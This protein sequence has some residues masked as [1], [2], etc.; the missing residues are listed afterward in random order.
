MNKR[1]GLVA[2]FALI[3]AIAHGADNNIMLG[4][5]ELYL[6]ASA[7]A[8]S[9]PPVLYPFQFQASSPTS[10]AITLPAS[11]GVQLPADSNGGYG[12]STFYTT[13]AAMDAAYPDGTY[14][15]TP[16]GSAPYTLQLINDLYPAAPPTLV[17]GGTWQNGVLV[18]DPTQNATL[19]INT[20]PGYGSGNGSHEE[21]QVNSESGDNVNL[22]QSI[23]SIAVA[24]MPATTTPFTTLAIPSGTLKAGYVYQATINFDAVGT[25]ISS[26]TLAVS[27]FSDSTYFYIVG[28]STPAVAPPVITSQP[29][30]QV[31]PLGSSVTFNIGVTYNGSTSS[32]SNA[33]TSY[34][35]Y[36]NGGPINY[37]SGNNNKYYFNGSGLTVNNLTAAD[38]G[39]YAVEIVNGGGLAESQSAT[40]TIGAAQAPAITGALSNQTVSTTTPVTFSVVATGTGPLNYQWFFNGVSITN[41]TSST[42]TVNNVNASTAGVYMVTVS[43]SVG[44]ASSS[45]TLT[46][47]VPTFP[48]FSTQPVSQMIASG[49]TVEFHVKATG[50]PA[51]TYQWTYNGGNI[52]GATSN[53]Y[54][55]FGATAANAGNY[56]CKAING[57]G[58]AISST[59]V[60]QVVTTN[61]PGHLDNLS[62]LS[63]ITSSLTMGF[64]TGGAG[65]SGLESLLIR[66][67]GPSLGAPPFNYPGTMPDPTLTV[68][69]QNTHTT[70][71]TNAGWGTP[72]SNIALVQTADAA[73]GAFALVST[74]SLDSALVESLAA[75][76][77]G[78]SVV[79]SGKSGDSGNAI[80]EVYDVN[81]TYTA[82]STRLI[83]LSCITTIPAGGALGVGFVLGGTTNKTLLIRVS[84]PTLATFGTPGTMAD[85]QLVITPQSNG[86]IIL[87]SNAGWAG[88]PVI[89]AVAASI[90]AFGFT[91][92]TSLDSAL[93][94]TLPPAVPYTV[95][96]TS[97]SGGGG[98]I[99]VEIY[100]VP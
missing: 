84:G 5:S 75:V 25:L 20:F 65:T 9:A 19:T 55:L 95:E 51:P 37:G 3:T 28:K 30:N 78:Y 74:G 90:G 93:V 10:A 11:S 45:A 60:L 49:T 50:F 97:V 42:Y 56:A 86:A 7:S 24:G 57:S 53:R 62:I 83:N 68:V 69:Q 71:A 85:P 26:P 21:F 15:I 72:S 91:S 47:N 89:S 73:T 32:P 46:V 54:V 8:P 23:V 87:A 33:P 92:T 34:Q 58:T 35:W 79:V 18:V 61:A 94:L 44:S 59:A 43:N 63:N 4:K 31:G 70:L 77:G 39:T 48:S 67:D 17:S 6:Q 16:A 1:F 96:V 99:L 38:V 13:K 12:I 98:A 52:S 100:E 14:Q 2:G 88:D 36:F 80:T 66:A 22:D 27:L 81:P 29:T 82:T 64:V 76:G 40:F 41:A